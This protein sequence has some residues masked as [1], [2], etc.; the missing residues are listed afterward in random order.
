MLSTEAFHGDITAKQAQDLLK[1]YGKPNTY[2]VRFSS[3]PGL[4]AISTLSEDKKPNHYR[5]IYSVGKGFY[6]KNEYY[7]SITK[8]LSKVKDVLGLDKACP[9]SKFT[10]L[11]TTETPYYSTA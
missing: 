7:E 2:L 1:S 5:V 10:D 6:Y 4:Y 3:N 9:G 8:L 11:L